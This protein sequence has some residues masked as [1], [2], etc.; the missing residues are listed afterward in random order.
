MNNFGDNVH[1]VGMFDLLA[2][3]W[4]KPEM[5]EGLPLHV[6][7]LTC[8]VAASALASLPRDF[9]PAT[10]T[11]ENLQLGVHPIIEMKLSV[12]NVEIRWL[13]DAKDPGV[14][15]DISFWKDWKFMP[16]VVG[17]EQGTEWGYRFYLP[18]MPAIA[19]TPGELIDP[20]YKC[21]E[22]ELWF[23]MV[24]H[25]KSHPT[26]YPLMSARVPPVPRPDE[27]KGIKRVL[28]PAGL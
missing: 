6:G 10:M 27:F 25:I 26:A 17:V 21:G 3:F 4:R 19:L 24:E 16:I 11:F 1:A 22:T 23:S 12:G 28:S 20:L 9:S 7:A 15:Q 8:P 18:E 5:P 2:R 14:W 13:A